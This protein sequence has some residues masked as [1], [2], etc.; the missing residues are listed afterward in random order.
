M[1]EIHPTQWL[2]E[3]Q[4]SVQSPT[5]PH[6][7][8]KS[9]WIYRWSGCQIYWDH[10]MLPEFLSIYIILA[11]FPIVFPSNNMSRSPVGICNSNRPRSLVG[12]R[13]TL[14]RQRKLHQKGLQHLETAGFSGNCALKFANLVDNPPELG[15]LFK[16][17]HVTYFNVVSDMLRW[18]SLAP[19]GTLNDFSYMNQGCRAIPSTPSG[20]SNVISNSGVAGADRLVKLGFPTVI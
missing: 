19:S 7:A 18:E 12:C 8:I 2:F 11:V 14:W 4:P 6:I 20:I 5:P 16:Q 9:P 13:W 10:K 17:T 1:A 15:N 3:P